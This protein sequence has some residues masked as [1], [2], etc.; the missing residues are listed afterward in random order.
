[1]NLDSRYC[2]YLTLIDHKED[3]SPGYRTLRDL[4]M[5]GMMAGCHEVTGLTEEP[6]EK[7][8]NRSCFLKSEY[9]FTN[10]IYHNLLIPSFVDEHL[11]YSY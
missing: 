8:G 4:P 1:M 5:F 7:G 11:G 6:L 3:L 10:S 2:P 9:Y